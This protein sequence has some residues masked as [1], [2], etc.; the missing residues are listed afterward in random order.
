[1]KEG[2]MYCATN[3]ARGIKRD[4]EEQQQ[5]QH[6]HT[7]THLIISLVVW[8]EAYYVDTQRRATMLYEQQYIWPRSY[9]ANSLRT[10]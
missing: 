8:V 4:E 2:T 3:S 5:K 1:M 10:I 6:T 7:H 9:T